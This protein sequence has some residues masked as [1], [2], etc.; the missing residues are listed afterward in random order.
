M[1]GSFCNKSYACHNPDLTEV[2]KYETLEWFYYHYYNPHH[3]HHKI[4]IVWAEHHQCWYFFTEL[5]KQ[6][7][8]LA[9]FMDGVYNFPVITCHVPSV[10]FDLKR[11]HTDSVYLLYCFCSNKKIMG[12]SCRL[13]W[14]SWFMTRFSNNWITW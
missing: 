14:L 12:L 6:Y 10:W 4:H 2:N 9:V 8:I 1:L 3:I 11:Q 7:I 5:L 13:S